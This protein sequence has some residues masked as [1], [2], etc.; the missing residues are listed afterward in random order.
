MLT[1]SQIL[2][3]LHQCENAAGGILSQIRGN[4]RTAEWLSTVWGAELLPKQRPRLGEY[5]MSLRR[6][7]VPNQIFALNCK[8]EN[9]FCWRWPLPFRK[10]LDHRRML[11]ITQSSDF[12]R[13][14]QSNLDVPNLIIPLLSSRQPTEFSLLITFNRFSRTDECMQSTICTNKD[15]A[16]LP[17]S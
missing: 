16:C 8:Q 17:L 7:G 15:K 14:K 6:R 13:K 11:K 2:H 10:I 9:S 3:L 12:L 1:D 4:L 5:H